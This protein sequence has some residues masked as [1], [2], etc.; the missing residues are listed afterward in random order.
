MLSKCGCQFQ[1]LKWM[2]NLHWMATHWQG[3]SLTTRIR[4]LVLATTVY[5]IWMERND[6][7][8]TNSYQ[9]VGAIVGSISN[10]IQSKLL[11]LEGIED[12]GPNRTVQQ[13]WSL[14]DS[15]FSIDA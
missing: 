13:Q 14:P 10:L 1:S 5:T 15:I 7:F 4:K 2:D 11:S 12:N 8:H 3:K 9:D 6:R